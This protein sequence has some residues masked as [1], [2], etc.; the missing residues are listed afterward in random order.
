MFHVYLTEKVGTR[1]YREGALKR[2]WDGNQI[3]LREE[4][5]LRRNSQFSPIFS[6]FLSSKQVNA[7][8]N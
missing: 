8:F 7:W 4:F 6:T 1:M 2:G 5:E 3:E